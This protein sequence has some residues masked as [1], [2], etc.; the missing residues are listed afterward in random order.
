MHGH[1]NVKNIMYLCFSTGVCSAKHP[2]TN[3]NYVYKNNFFLY[4]PNV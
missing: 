3:I 2:E 4:L 1:L